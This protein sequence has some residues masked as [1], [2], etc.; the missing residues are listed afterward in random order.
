M[1]KNSRKKRQP[2]DDAAYQRLWRFAENYPNPCIAVQH[3]TQI[4]VWLWGDA[5][6]TAGCDPERVQG[7]RGWLLDEIE[8][9]LQRSWD[10]VQNLPHRP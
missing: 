8:S 2:F 9:D 7:E 6:V 3:L 5:A 4:L 10:T 1:I